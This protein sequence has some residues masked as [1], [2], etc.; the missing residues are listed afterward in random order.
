MNILNFVIGYTE[1][2]CRLE[3][4]CRV[5]NGLMDG[6][7]EFF[8][9]YENDGKTYFSVFNKSING[10]GDALSLC[11]DV[12]RVCLSDVIKRGLSRP[13]LLLG[14]VFC[15]ACMY[16]STLFLWDI[17]YADG[18][19]LEELMTEAGLKIGAYIPDINEDIIEIRALMNTDKYSYISININGTSASVDCEKRQSGVPIDSS[20]PSNLVAKCDGVIVRYE[21]YSGDGVCSVG[22]TVSEGQLLISGIDETK[23]HGSRIVRARGAVYACTEKE[24]T[25]S[26]PTVIYEKQY[27]GNQSLKKRYSM[28]GMSVDTG[29]CGSYELYDTETEKKKLKIFGSVELPIYVTHEKKREYVYAERTLTEQQARY[30]AQLLYFERLKTELE[31]CQVLSRSVKTEFDGETV[32]VHCRLSVIQNIAKEVPITVG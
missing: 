32:S 28:C 7:T 6:K 15:L 25:V 11:T 26:Y 12:K 14:A 20:L 30:Q 3:D 17:H 4:T 27:T 5:L 21:V 10:A 19:E 8:N 18:Q 31:G 13:G 24:F 29:T 2:C 22:Q 23:H 16:V 1:Y 9:Q